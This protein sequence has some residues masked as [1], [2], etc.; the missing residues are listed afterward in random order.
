VTES[1]TTDLSRV[2]GA[3]VIARNTAFTFKGNGLH[4][5]PLTGTQANPTCLSNSI[6]LRYPIVECRRLE[7]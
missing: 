7:L 6:G 1:L 5:V 4:P 2:S 3:F